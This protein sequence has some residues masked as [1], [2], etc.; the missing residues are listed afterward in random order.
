MGFSTCRKQ[1]SQP[2]ACAAL[3]KKER[4]HG[5]VPPGGYPRAKEMLSNLLVRAGFFLQKFPC[6]Y[7]PHYF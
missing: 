6:S 7:E 4:F 5:I 1:P 3:G 2:A